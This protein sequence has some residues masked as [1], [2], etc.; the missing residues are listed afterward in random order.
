MNR[1]VRLGIDFVLRQRSKSY[2]NNTLSF[3]YIN[4]IFI[5]YLNKLR[6]S[7]DFPRFQAVLLTDNCSPYMGDAVIAIVTRE[8]VRVIIFASHTT[9]IF[10]MLDVMLFSALEKYATGL[11]TLEKQQPAA[12]FLLKVYHDFKQMMVEVNIWGAFAIIGSTLNIE[13]NPYR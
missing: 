13:K 3:E 11:G 2:V 5:L 8:R 1:G 4:N 7:E 6:E 12:A 10:K 9:H